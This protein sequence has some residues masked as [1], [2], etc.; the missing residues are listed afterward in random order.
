MGAGF[1]LMA[2][3]STLFQIYVFW[4]LFMG[5]TLG[6]CVTPILTTIPKWFIRKRA[7]AVTFPIVGFGIGS[8]IAP[9]LAQ[10]LISAYDWREAYSILGIAAWVILIPLSQLFKKDP[11]RMGYQPYGQPAT[12]HESASII[13]DKDMSLHEALKTIPFWILCAIKFLFFFCLQAIVIHIVPYAIDSGMEAIVAAGVLSILAIFSV[14][15]R[16]SM[17]FIFDRIGA[18]QS[19]CLCLLLAAVSLVWLFLANNVWAV[20][21]FAV[22]FGLA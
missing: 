13:C 21:V 5:L 12:T 10:W 8:I 17:G 3:I 11:V 19:L 4:G 14:I 2:H 20:Y 6:C 1:L 18:I 9:L 22:F 7:L 16:I 15:G